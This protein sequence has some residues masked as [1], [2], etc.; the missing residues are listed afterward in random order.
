M[1]FATLQNVLQNYEEG[2]RYR[3][4]KG[5]EKTMEGLRFG[6]LY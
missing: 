1:S 2:L 3:D 6:E 5:K 4:L